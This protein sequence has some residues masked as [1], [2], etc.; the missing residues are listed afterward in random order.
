MSYNF[1]L[2]TLNFEL[3]YMQSF[4][5]IGSDEKGRLQ[6][7]EKF[8]GKK[9]S[10]LKNNPDFILLEKEEGSSIGIAEVRLLQ[11]K[12]SLKP[13]RESKKIAL[14]KEAQDLTTEAQ[15]ALLKTLEE[16]NATTLI[17]LTSPDT[18][19]LFPTIVSRCQIVRLPAKSETAI[20]EKEFQ[21]ISEILYKLLAATPA[22]RFKLLEEEGIVK[23]R[24]SATKWLDKLSLVTR[25]IIL[26]SYNVPS[27][28]ETDQKPDIPKALSKQPA[29]YF[30]YI[31]QIINK[32]K[33]YLEANC[34]V[35]LT[36]E[37]FLTKI[38]RST[39]KYTSGVL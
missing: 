4:L 7:V 35:K 22:K 25:Q 6:E 28:S 32:Y 8:I 36:M 27:L 23:D 14:I 11:E 16:P 20:E 18:F 30:F 17:I 13:F 1:E 24:E 9:L 34:N 15:N 10:S 3:I 39:R 37:V 29:G 5:I 31:L 26:T 19:W 12:L 38:P 21:N 2:C 33:K